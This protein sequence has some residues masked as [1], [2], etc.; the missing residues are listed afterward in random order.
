LFKQRTRANAP[1]GPSVSVGGLVVR[2]GNPVII[3][4]EEEGGREVIAKAALVN[5]AID[6]DCDDRTWTPLGRRRDR[7]ETIFERRGI[8]S[9]LM[10]YFTLIALCKPLE[11]LNTYLVNL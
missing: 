7:F 8:K 11:V 10:C 3:T 5:A 4:I 9:A 6:S 2:Q 1:F